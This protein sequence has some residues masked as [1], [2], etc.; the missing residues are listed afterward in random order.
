MPVMMQLLVLDQGTNSINYDRRF[1]SVPAPVSDL[2][3]K[4]I[5]CFLLK[6][7]SISR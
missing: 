7:Q 2:S 5:M 6:K 3:Q 1:P 4:A